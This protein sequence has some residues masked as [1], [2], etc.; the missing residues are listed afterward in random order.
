MQNTLLENLMG[1]IYIIL[2]F[3][4]AFVS[5]LRLSIFEYFW[6]S[7]KLNLKNQKKLFKF[8]H[9]LPDIWHQFALNCQFF[10]LTYTHHVTF[11]KTKGKKSLSTPS[12]RPKK[13]NMEITHKYCNCFLS[14]T[15]KNIKCIY[16]KW[17][18]KKLQPWV[19]LQ[20]Q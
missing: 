4:W 11:K 2:V 14:D 18:M 17:A 9:K 19:S 7:M 12:S 13:N 15:I 16:S 8:I 5:I 3:V 20:Q 10:C 1:Y 6:K